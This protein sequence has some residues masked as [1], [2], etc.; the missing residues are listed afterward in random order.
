MRGT[1]N[2]KKI[3]RR[4]RRRKERKKYKKKKGQENSIENRHKT[5]I[6]QEPEI[7]SLRYS[8]SP[9]PCTVDLNSFMTSICIIFA[10]V[11][12]AMSLSLLIFNLRP[13]RCI[14]LQIW[15]VKSDSDSNP[16]VHNKVFRDTVGQ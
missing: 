15:G 11:N 16:D 6:E 5:K 1:I 12:I 2:L 9:R 4:K 8:P 14:T 3:R 10:V 13:H 7:A